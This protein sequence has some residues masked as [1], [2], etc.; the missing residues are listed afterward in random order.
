MNLTCTE[1]LYNRA[2]HQKQEQEQEHNTTEEELWKRPGAVDWFAGPSTRFLPSGGGRRR[3]GLGRDALRPAALFWSSWA[4]PSP[5]PR[6]AELGGA[7]CCWAENPPAERRPPSGGVGRR[8]L[9]PGGELAWWDRPPL[10]GDEMAWAATGWTASRAAA[11]EASLAGLS[12]GGG[13]RPGLLVLGRSPAPSV[14]AAR[15]LTVAVVRASRPW[16]GRGERLLFS[17]ITRA[18]S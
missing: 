4:A 12:G 6:S 11:A 15:Q 8:P 13:R 17:L 9:L 7:T 2:V 10:P 5:A 14:I 18:W 1:K 16:E 3:P